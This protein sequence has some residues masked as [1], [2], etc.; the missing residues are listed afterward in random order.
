MTKKCKIITAFCL[1]CSVG[2]HAQQTGDVFQGMLHEPNSL[3][4]PT[5]R[6]RLI[7]I[8]TTTVTI[9]AILS[10]IKPT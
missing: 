4:Q 8:S 2:V 5:H 1:L 10:G 9:R 6:K 7:C 3:L